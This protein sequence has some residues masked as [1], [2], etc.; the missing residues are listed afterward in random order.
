MSV[1]ATN[2]DL[3]DYAEA[4]KKMLHESMLNAAFELLK[5]NENALVAEFM[6]L[7]KLDREGTLEE[8]RK[9]IRKDAFGFVF[10]IESRS[11]VKLLETREGLKAVAPAETAFELPSTGYCSME[12]G[13]EACQ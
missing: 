9:G 3:V 6:P 2:T 8:I 5:Q 10:R 7:T 13:C 4:A 1:L 11:F 12:P